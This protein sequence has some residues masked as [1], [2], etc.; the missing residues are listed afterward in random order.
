M[1]PIASHALSRSIRSVVAVQPLLANHH[2]AL[3]APIVS[4]A[5]IA[6]IPGAYV[7]TGS[8]VSSV[9]FTKALQ[10][11]LYGLHATPL[12]GYVGP[13]VYGFRYGGAPLIVADPLAAKKKA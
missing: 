11:H 1:L 6:H 9:T 2:V 10:G 4:H 3:A 8:G 13:S 5:H 7:S 12:A